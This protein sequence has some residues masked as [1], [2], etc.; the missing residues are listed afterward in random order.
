MEKIEGINKLGSSYSN[1]SSSSPATIL[2]NQNISHL[3]NLL[4][5]AMLILE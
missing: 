4:K 5:I 2:K 3:P 1:T